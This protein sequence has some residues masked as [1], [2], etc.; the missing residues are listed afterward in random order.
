MVVNINAEISSYKERVVGN[1]TLRQI[2]CLIIALF[3][4]VTTYFYLN[5]QKDIKQLTV[6]FTVL[7]IVAI[8]FYSYQGVT[9]ELYLYY[10]IREFVFPQK[11][12]FLPEN[13]ELLI[14]DGKRGQRKDDDKKLIKLDKKRKHPKI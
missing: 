2:I 3:I 1:Y 6:I 10:M 8:G 7:P 14:D 4:G 5:I 11:R 9:C 13:E 12:V